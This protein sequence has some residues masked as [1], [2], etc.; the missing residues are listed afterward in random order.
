MCSFASSPHGVGSRDGSSTTF[1]SS[2]PSISTLVVTNLL[3]IG[4]RPSCD[5][6]HRLHNLRVCPAATQIPAHSVS[7]LCLGWVRVLV[8]QRDR[9]ENLPR[10]AESALH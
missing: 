5:T 3:A 4:T 1:V 6:E 7:D 9:G 2:R 10:R 8:E